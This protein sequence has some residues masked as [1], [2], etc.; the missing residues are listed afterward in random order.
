MNVKTSEHNDS[1]NR[2]TDIQKR[3]EAL[4]YSVLILDLED[5]IPPESEGVIC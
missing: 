2:K 3:A 5:T 1:L 4:K